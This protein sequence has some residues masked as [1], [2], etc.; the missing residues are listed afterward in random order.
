MND[1]EVF[2]V[3]VREDFT[4]SCGPAAERMRIRIG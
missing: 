4:L 2:R 3:N 1:F